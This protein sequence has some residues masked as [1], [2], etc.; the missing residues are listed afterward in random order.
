METETGDETKVKDTENIFNKN[1]GEN[2]PNLKKID[3]YQGTRIIKSTKQT[4]QEKNVLF[5]HY[6]Q[7]AKLPEQKTIIKSSKG[8]TFNNI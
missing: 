8:K 3:A 2:F 1:T 7:K 5:R 6:N 4:G